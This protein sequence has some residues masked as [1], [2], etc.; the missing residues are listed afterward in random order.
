MNRQAGK[1]ALMLGL[2]LANETCNTDSGSRHA[3]RWAVRVWSAAD[4]Y[5]VAD[6]EGLTAAPEREPPLIVVLD[7]LG[8]QVG[9]R[10]RF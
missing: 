2:D 5:G 6:R 3:V 4:S 10:Y 1:G 8:R 9:M 7:P